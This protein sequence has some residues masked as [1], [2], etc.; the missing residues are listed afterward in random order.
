MHF[1]GSAKFSLYMAMR[2]CL[3]HTVTVVHENTSP[4]GHQKDFHDFTQHIKQK[5]NDHIKYHPVL[6]EAHWS[7]ASNSLIRYT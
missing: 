4:N 2:P 1:M 3:T 5:S 6:L 7:V